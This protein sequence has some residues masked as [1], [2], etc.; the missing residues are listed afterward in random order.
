MVLTHLKHLI[1]YI[2]WVCECDFFFL[3]SIF[4]YFDKRQYV[5]FSIDD[6]N[7]DIAVVDAVL[8]QP[9]PFGI[10]FKRLGECCS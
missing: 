6:E 5:I 9:S 4:N 3:D 8:F 2:N 1:G 7:R 10:Y